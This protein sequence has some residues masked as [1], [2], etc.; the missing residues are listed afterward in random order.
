MPIQ[1]FGSGNAVLIKSP[2]QGNDERFSTG[3]PTEKI[4]AWEVWNSRYKRQVS[5][6]TK[7]YNDET[8]CILRT[9]DK[10]AME[11]Q[12]DD[13]VKFNGYTYSVQSVHPVK[14][15]LTLNSLDYEVT[16]K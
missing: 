7:I 5:P 15:P 9:H 13:G 1:P 3:K 11:L 10:L 14:T 12:S 4:I 2:R 16:L 8:T 6:Y